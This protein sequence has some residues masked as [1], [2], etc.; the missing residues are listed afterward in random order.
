MRGRTRPPAGQMFHGEGRNFRARWERGR[1][2]RFAP[3]RPARCRLLDKTIKLPA[4]TGPLQPCRSLI[5]RGIN[6]VPRVPS[7]PI[8]SFRCASLGLRS[9][10]AR[11]EPPEA[12]ES[13]G[14]RE[15]PVRATPHCFM[16]QR[17]LW[18]SSAVTFSG[19]SGR[20]TSAVAVFD[21]LTLSTPRRLGVPS[22]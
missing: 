7:V 21:P 3:G 2:V 19:R 18:Y 10:R 9:V 13:G 8:V 20:G 11:T 6:C 12:R 1:P 22:T 5:S 16:V 4:T 15:Q 17:M 14:S